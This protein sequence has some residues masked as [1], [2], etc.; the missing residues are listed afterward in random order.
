[1][2][3]G[4]KGGKINTASDQVQLEAKLETKIGVTLKAGI[5]ASAKAMFL[6]YGKAS[7]KAGLTAEA[8]VAIRGSYSFQWDTYK[9]LLFK[10]GLILDPCVAKVAMFVEVGL[11]YKVV[12]ADWKPINVNENRTFWKAY[13][14]MQ[15]VANFT[16][17]SA[18]FFIYK[19]NS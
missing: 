14:V 18:E 13:D 5:V 19:P 12:S 8:S 6:E 9:G 2:A 1:M 4:I 10:P 16:G 3:G 15:G 17:R 7:V 11:S